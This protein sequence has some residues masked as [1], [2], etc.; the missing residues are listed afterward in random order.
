MNRKSDF[1]V[2]THISAHISMYKQRNE[3]KK[4]YNNMKQNNKS[5]LRS[6]TTRFTIEMNHEV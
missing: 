2:H 4:H 3:H 6:L 1:L 5:E